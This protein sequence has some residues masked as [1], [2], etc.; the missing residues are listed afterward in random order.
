MALREALADGTI[1]VVA[2]DHAPHPREDKEC[3]WARGGHGHDRAGDRA[4]RG[5]ARRWSRPA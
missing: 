2:T 3:E 5:P 1:D 4:V